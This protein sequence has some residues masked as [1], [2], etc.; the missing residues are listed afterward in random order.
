M[1][2]VAGF[3]TADPSL[4]D[5]QGVLKR[6]GDA[7]RHRGPDDEGI[8]WDEDLGAGFAHRRLS[9]VDLSAEGRQPMSSQS[10]RYVIAYNGEVYNFP[11]LRKDL[12]GRGVAFRGR[13]DTEVMLA[14]IEAH[15]LSEAVQSYSGMFAFALF[16][17]ATRSLSLVRDRL[18]EK[19][20]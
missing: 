20:L 2:G 11:D 18:G 9:I 19:P 4:P 17:R 1:C 5:P 13:S 3:W 14:A 15:G 6:M 12:A 10:G 7:V 8:W 16:D